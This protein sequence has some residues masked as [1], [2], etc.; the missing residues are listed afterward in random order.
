MII[1]NDHKNLFF[2]FF[3]SLVAF[4]PQKFYFTFIFLMFLVAF[5]LVVFFCVTSTSCEENLS[6]IIKLVQAQL[7][8]D[9]S[10]TFFLLFFLGS[11]SPFL[12]DHKHR[13]NSFRL[14][15]NTSHHQFNLI[16]NHF[17]WFFKHWTCTGIL[18][19]QVIT[20]K[21]WFIIHLS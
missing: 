20:G 12:P 16:S 19:H 21:L 8:I 15:A 18:R 1:I 2:L 17:R 3:F 11:F 6:V 9:F 7:L 5:D 14:Y 4:W 10:I 13:T